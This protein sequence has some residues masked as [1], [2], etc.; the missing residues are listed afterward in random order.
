MEIMARQ[1]ID[2]RPEVKFFL[3]RAESDTS[4]HSYT[5][6]RLKELGEWEKND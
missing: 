5:T 6:Y 4:K 2:P 1:I 3:A